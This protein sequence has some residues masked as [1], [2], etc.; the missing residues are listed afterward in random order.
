[1]ISDFIKIHI[2]PNQQHLVTLFYKVSGV[3]KFQN[4]ILKVL[5]CGKFEQI[6]SSDESNLF[7]LKYYLFQN[8]E[9]VILTSNNRTI[10]IHIAASMKFKLKHLIDFDRLLESFTKL[11]AYNLLFC[12]FSEFLIFF[13]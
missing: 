1:M 13:K 5:T 11:F 10:R 3:A 4:W 6:E 9:S 2:L 8:L 7:N 12:F